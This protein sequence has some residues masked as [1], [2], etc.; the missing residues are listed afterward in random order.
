MQSVEIDKSTE[1]G[2]SDMAAQRLMLNKKNKGMENIMIIAT[3]LVLA[4]LGIGIGIG[5][6]VGRKSSAAPASTSGCPCVDTSALFT[7]HIRPR[8]WGSSCVAW[9]KEPFSAKLWGGACAEANPPDWCADAYCYVDPKTCNVGSYQ[10]D[11]GAVQAAGLE[12]S[13]KT[14]NASFTGN[15]WVGDCECTG[16]TGVFNG[17][18]RP[19]NWGAS[20]AAWNDGDGKWPDCVS[21]TPP[22]W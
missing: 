1:L 19:T 7:G 13:Y 6:S 15:S 16:V 2:S 22:D 9:D 11:I 14:C 20:C 8:N 5:V 12:W 3:V 10:S 18:E 21:E 4:F 17:T